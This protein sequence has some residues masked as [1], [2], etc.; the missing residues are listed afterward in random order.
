MSEPTTTWATIDEA[1]V[2]LGKT[3]RTIYRKIQDGLLNTQTRQDGT[4]LVEL[5]APAVQVA[6]AKAFAENADE[7]KKLS[8]HLADSYAMQLRH[9]SDNLAGARRNSRRLAV[10]VTTAAVVILGLGVT[11][12]QYV[13][14]LES[15]RTAATMNESRATRAESKLDGLERDYRDLV[16]DRDL[17]MT[18]VARLKVDAFCASLDSFP[19]ATN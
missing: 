6:A 13:T 8:V 1:A 10:S 15:T 16:K 3:P 17:A 2:V 5:A 12:S 19:D 4:V 11:L 18:E 9:V 7:S 14:A